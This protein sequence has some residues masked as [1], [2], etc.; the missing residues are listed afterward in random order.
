MLYIYFD[1]CLK[2]IL[3]FHAIKTTCNVVHRLRHLQKRC[4]SPI[5]PGEDLDLY[6]YRYSALSRVRPSPGGTQIP[7]FFQPQHSFP[8]TCVNWNAFS[9]SLN[10]SKS[11]PF[12]EP[13]Q[14]LLHLEMFCSP[15]TKDAISTSFAS[16]PPHNCSSLVFLFC[17]TGVLRASQ[18]LGKLSITWAMPP[19]LSVLGI[20]FFQIGSL[21]LGLGWLQREILLP[22]PPT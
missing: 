12:Q 11:N 21:A 14:M 1:D 22:I 4:M 13:V 20:Y 6:A 19:A 2:T 9:W 17:G 15:N 8:S 10:L 16:V 7:L 5:E 18:L 3:Y